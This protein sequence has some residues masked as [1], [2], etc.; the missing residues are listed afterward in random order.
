MYKEKVACLQTSLSFAH[1]C[2]SGLVQGEGMD[3]PQVDTGVAKSVGQ[4]CSIVMRQRDACLY[5]ST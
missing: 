2:P 5:I 4:S 1:V 3:L